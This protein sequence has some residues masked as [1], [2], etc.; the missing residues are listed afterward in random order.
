MGHE[1]EDCTCADTRGVCGADGGRDAPPEDA[2]SAPPAPVEPDHCFTAESVFGFEL[3]EHF[4]GPVAAPQVL[5]GYER[6]VPGAARELIACHV[7]S[8]SVASDALERTSRAE[9]TAV[10]IGVVGA[11]VLTVGALVAGC[12]LIM[13][14][15]GAT[16]LVA[17]VPGV[18][19]AGAQL[20]SA[21]RRRP[22][23]QE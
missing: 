16:A 21:T 17:L 1:H 10:V 19:G 2:G 7:R 22:S 12:A 15:H 20:L 5:A 9:A 6:L 18:L 14:G 11:Q 8:E 23:S 4:S 13:N 3:A